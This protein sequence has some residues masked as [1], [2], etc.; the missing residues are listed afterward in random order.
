MSYIRSEGCNILETIKST[1]QD[2]ISDPTSFGK[3]YTQYLMTV[4]DESMELEMKSLI[5][6]HRVT[7]IN[8]DK[9]LKSI[10]ATL[11]RGRKLE[12]KIED[13]AIT[14]NHIDVSKPLKMR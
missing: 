10:Y 2:S 11:N 5:V 3:F 14:L 8:T 6:N 13:L 4:Q 9:Y 7:V 1:I 12:V